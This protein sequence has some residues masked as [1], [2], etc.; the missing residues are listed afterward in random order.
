[1]D[2]LK[3][4]GRVRLKG[5]LMFGHIESQFDKD[6]VVVIFDD[7]LAEPQSV[8]LRE[9]SPCFIRQLIIWLEAL[10]AKVQDLKDNPKKEARL[11]K[12]LTTIFLITTI[13]LS[14]LV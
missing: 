1:M 13:L 2:M 12:G 7:N 10:E 6:T 14:F 3:I 5:T 9:L 11:Y 4:G 8:K